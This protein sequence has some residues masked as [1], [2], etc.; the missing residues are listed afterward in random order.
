MAKRIIVVGAGFSGVALV[1]QLLRQAQVPLDITVF[2]QR[3]C[4]ALGIAYGTTETVHLL[5]VPAAGM[6]MYPDQADHFVQWLQAGGYEQQIDLD[7]RTLPEAFVPRYIYG[8]YLQDNFAKSIAAAQGKH[9]VHIVH[10]QVVALDTDDSGVRVS[11]ACGGLHSA[12]ACVLAFGNGQPHDLLQRYQLPA[13]R[14]IANGWASQALDQLAP[15]AKVLIIG[16]GL[17]TVDIILSLLARGFNGAIT[18]VSRRGLSPLAHRYGLAKINYDAATLPSRLRDVVRFMRE[19]AANAADWRMAVDA[20]RP[21]TQRLWAGLSD[22]EKSQFLR[23]PSA[24]WGIHRHRIAPH[25]AAKLAGLTE[26]G[27]LLQL[28]GRIESVSEA[29]NGLSVALR[30]RSDNSLVTVSADMIIN[31]TGPST[32]YTRQAAPLIQ[33]LLARGYLTPTAI[34]D[35]VYMDAQSRLLNHAH[36]PLAHVYGMGILTRYRDWENIAV[37]DIRQQAAELAK[38]LNSTD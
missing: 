2:E 25:I 28:S 13:S 26:S 22:W 9:A 19:Q 37:P 27:R 16:N 3:E 15:D 4:H 11:L 34:C 23:H 8:R 29:A 33:D 7:G 20:L 38:T 31:C 12:D 1:C 35:G 6:S 18:A 14:Y 36:Q 30:K 21:H 17:T 5:N 10:E 32:H 24:V